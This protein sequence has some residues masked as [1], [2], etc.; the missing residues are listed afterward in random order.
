M[1][2]YWGSEKGIIQARSLSEDFLESGILRSGV[3]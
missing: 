1:P 2:F 3:Q